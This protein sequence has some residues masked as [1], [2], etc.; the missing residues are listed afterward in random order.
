MSV[1]HVFRIACHKSGNQTSMLINGAG[2]ESERDA[3]HR[4]RAVL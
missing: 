4:V 2:L 3:E 1:P